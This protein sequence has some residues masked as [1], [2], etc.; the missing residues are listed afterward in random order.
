MTTKKPVTPTPA[1]KPTAPERGWVSAAAHK[2]AEKL[3]HHEEPKPR[4][5]KHHGWK[6][7]VCG[8]ADIDTEV[9]PVDGSAR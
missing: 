5:P 7:E 6:C 8:T 9:C 3:T 2:V 1:E 4:A